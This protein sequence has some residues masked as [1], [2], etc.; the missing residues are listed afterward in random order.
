MSN[1]IACSSANAA[2]RMRLSLNAGPAFSENRLLDTAH[3]LEQSL[4]FDGS[5]A[6]VAA[7][8]ERGAA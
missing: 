4:A 1:P 3:A 5:K 7:G 2:S 8:G 6:R